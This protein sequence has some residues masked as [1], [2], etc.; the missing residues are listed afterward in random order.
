MARVDGRLHQFGPGL[1]AELLVGHFETART[2]G[3]A[4][5]APTGEAVAGRFAAGVEIHVVRRLAGR[6]FAEIKERG[7]TVGHSDQHETAAAEIAGVRVSDSQREAHRHG[8]V[9]GV[10]AGFEDRHADVGGDRLL[11]DNH[12]VASMNR[13]PDGRVHGQAGDRQAEDEEDRRDAHRPRFYYVR[14]RSSA[15]MPFHRIWTPMQ[16]RMNDDNRLMTF[17]AV[18]PSAVPM[19][20]AKR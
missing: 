12:D 10:A 3:Y 8:R 17:M 11:G 7:A 9:D 19:R 18:S 20:S 13:L 15:L 2:A 16:T 1:F 6:A 5:R 14:V 4:G